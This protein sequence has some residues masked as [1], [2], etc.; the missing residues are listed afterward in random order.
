MQAENEIQL[1]STALLCMQR[2]VA[3]SVGNNF[4][5]TQNVVSKTTV[6][7]FLLR[8][9]LVLIAIFHELLNRMVL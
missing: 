8:G 7:Y 3:L 9:R 5:S 4:N 6:L 2:C 1:S